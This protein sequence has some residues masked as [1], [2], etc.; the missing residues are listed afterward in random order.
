MFR[1]QKHI[2]S[3]LL[4]YRNDYNWWTN[5]EVCEH[6]ESSTSF[7][8]PTQFLQFVWVPN[9]KPI[10]ELFF[11]FFLP[12]NATHYS[13][14]T[15]YCNTKTLIITCLTAM[16]KKGGSQEHYAFFFHGTRLGCRNCKNS[17]Q[18]KKGVGEIAHKKNSLLHHIFQNIFFLWTCICKRRLVIVMAHNEIGKLV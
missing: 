12:P 16:K 11:H 1:G 10:D 14:M 18:K 2:L 8:F 5:F 15:N 9:I 13:F 6:I 4:L 3:T 7:S 17:P